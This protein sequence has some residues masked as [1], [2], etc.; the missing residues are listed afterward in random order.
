MA[1]WFFFGTTLL[2]T[3]LSGSFKVSLWGDVPGQDGY[4]FYNVSSYLLVFAAISTHLRS[5][6]QMWRLL[7]VIVA[8]GT[9]IGGYALLQ[10]NCHD[11]LGTSEVTGG[12]V[13]GFA[14][15]TIFTAAVLLMTITVSV[16]LAVAT[17]PDPTAKTV[18]GLVA[19]IRRWAPTVLLA[20]VWC[21]VISTQMLALA[22]T[23]S[24]GP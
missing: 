16:G 10:A 12:Y 8:V 23:S 17:L 1:V 14:G 5:P 6:A 4:S 15:N 11:P 9:L 24:R 3:L 22:F 7:G 2:S 18:N 20:W 13:T 19:G 21:F